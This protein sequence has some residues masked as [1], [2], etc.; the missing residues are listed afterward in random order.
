MSTEAAASSTCGFLV[1]DIWSNKSLRSL[2]HLR[3]NDLKRS[4]KSKKDSCVECVIE[5]DLSPPLR[6]PNDIRRRRDLYRL[7]KLNVRLRG[8][9]PSVGL[10]REIWFRLGSLLCDLFI[11]ARTLRR[12]L[13]VRLAF[14][15]EDLPLSVADPGWVWLTPFTASTCE[16]QTFMADFKLVTYGEYNNNK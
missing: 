16:R 2:R 4:T 12:G 9:N 1:E 6:Q 7:V 5:L 3:P 15:E 11:S 14:P 10:P 13:G 8:R